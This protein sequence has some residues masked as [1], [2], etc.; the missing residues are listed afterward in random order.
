MII[1]DEPERFA[2]E[3]DKASNTAQIAQEEALD[4]HN[5]M[6]EKAP[7]DFDG[8]HCIDC[9]RSIPQDRLK[10]GAF[11]DIDCQQRHELKQKGYRK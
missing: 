10:T 11:R 9:D 8:T 3:G 2:D 1:P 6:V 5:R 4:R 7:P